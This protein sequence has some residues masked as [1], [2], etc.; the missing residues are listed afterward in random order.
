[1][2][3]LIKDMEMPK[4]CSECPMYS[5][6]ESCCLLESNGCVDRYNYDFNLIPDWCPLSE[7]SELC[8]DAVSRKGVAEAVEYYKKSVH[9]ILGDC[10]FERVADAIHGLIRAL[11]SAQPEPQWISCSE[12]LP[13]AQT[14]VIVSCTDDS[15]DT[16]FR[17]TSSG[18]VTTDKEYW[19]ADNEI[20]N[21][22]V[23]WMPLP[24]PY[25]EES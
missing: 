18:W 19:I 10:E 14:E 23:A 11:P 5:R 16:K 12:S 15:G 7:V 21:F 13:E 9:H 2:A 20:N 3:I 1:M 24:E 4:S 17:Y 25:Q 22:V 6:Y 8:E